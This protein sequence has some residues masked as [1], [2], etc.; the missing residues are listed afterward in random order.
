MFFIIFVAI[1]LQQGHPTLQN[2]NMKQL[3]RLTLKDMFETLSDTG[4]IQRE[5]TYL[6]DGL[7]IAINICRLF[8]PF[9][10][11]VQSPFVI[12]EYRIGIVKR[13]YMHGILN[14]QE[15]TVG[16]GNIIFV[17]P[18]SI[19]EPLDMSDDFMAM[20]LG[21][22]DERLQLAHSSNIPNIFNGQRK[23]DMQPIDDNA[24]RL[25]DHLVRMLWEIVNSKTDSGDT[26]TASP[27]HKVADRMLQTITAYI[28]E[29]FARQRRDTT[30]SH[31][32]NDIFNRFIALVNS[33]CREQRRLAFYADKICVTERYLGT[34]VRQTSGVT[35]K[36]WIDR[37]VITAAK[38]MLRHGNLPVAQIA[39][40]LNFPNPS[41]FCKYFKRMEGCTPQEFRAK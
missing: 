3:H 19:V 18:G 10:Q 34:V 20:G 40:R 17:M 36:E 39:E 38:V 35:A 7:G 28:D 4:I 31:T 5:N 16:A 22:S 11:N 12:D 13:G 2:G 25:F 1:F 33:H 30:N 23:H 9:V 14:L 21:I 6:K 37:A 8:K 32:A 26:D 27:S 15:Y 41:F 29:L 24:M